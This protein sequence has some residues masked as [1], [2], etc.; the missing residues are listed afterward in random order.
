MPSGIVGLDGHEILSDEEKAALKQ[1]REMIYGALLVEAFGALIGCTSKPGTRW[2]SDEH[3]EGFRKSLA[4]KIHEM[5]PAG[6]CEARF[7][8]KE[9]RFV[10]V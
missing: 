3:L 6:V 1:D 4:R 10:D 5:L 8:R 9:F 7:G 2:K